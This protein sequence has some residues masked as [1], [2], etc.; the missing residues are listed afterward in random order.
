MVRPT[1]SGAMAV[2]AKNPLEDLHLRAGASLDDGSDPRVPPQFEKDAEREYREVSTHAG[3]FDMSHR[4]R[5]QLSG[6]DAI[7]WLN[8]LVTN[9][10]KALVPGAGLRAVLT[11]PK[12]R[13]LDDLTLL[14][15]PDLFLV[16]TDA[17]TR[18]KVLEWF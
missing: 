1:S 15:S 14:L 4:G 6:K 11:T 18:K 9:D 12:G 2:M 5:L 8:S 17:T 16:G 10:V 7:E 13:V 3:L